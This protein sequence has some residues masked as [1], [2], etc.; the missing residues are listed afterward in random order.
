MRLLESK[1]ADGLIVAFTLGN[2]EYLRSWP[3]Q[4]LPLVNIDRLPSELNI[5]AVL[6]DNVAGAR[7]AVDH[8]IAPGHER[9]CIVTGLPGITSTEKP[10]TGYPPTLQAH[11]IS[12]NS[13]LI[14]LSHFRVD[15]GSGPA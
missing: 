9:I 4:R 1:R 7:Q 11:S 2:L 6:V 3:A 5:D 15:G 14:A 8:L 12:P 10:L 13:A